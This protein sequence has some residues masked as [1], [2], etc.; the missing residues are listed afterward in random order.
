MAQL[1]ARVGWWLDGSAWK[2]RRYAPSMSGRAKNDFSRIRSPFQGAL[3]RLR[4]IEEEDLRTIH[5]L[6]NDPE[7][8][9]TLAVNWPEPL[10]G[11]RRW[12]EGSRANPTTVPFA[13]ETL[14][15]E[16][17]GACSLEG[18][19]AAV[20]SAALGIWIGALH[21]DRG[22]GTDAVRTLCRFAFREMNLQRVGLAVY[23]NN[24]RGVRAYEK[25]GFKEEG[26]R[27]RA[28]FVEGRHMDVIVMGLLAEDLIED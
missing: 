13:I 18:I 5:D 23:E 4:A 8:Q 10:G 28:H 3:V 12:W 19:D 6:F 7:V 15:G 16:L 17:V 25:V 9:R 26:R 22:Y 27:R 21:W 1:Y 24:P 20:R 14:A 11:T 2:C